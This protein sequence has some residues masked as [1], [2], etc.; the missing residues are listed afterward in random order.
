VK[1][2]DLLSDHPVWVHPGVGAGQDLHSQFMSKTN[3]PT[4]GAECLDER[5]SAVETE[6]VVGGVPK[7]RIDGG[8]VKDICVLALAPSAG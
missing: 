1:E 3:L 2:A 7:H 5:G 6:H 4:V 8:E